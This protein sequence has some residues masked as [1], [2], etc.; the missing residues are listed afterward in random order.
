M[1]RK[2][3]VK[4][5]ANFKRNL[6]D[7]EHFLAEAEAPRACDSL[8]D[9]LLGTAIRNLERFPSMGRPFLA[10]AARS[11]ETANGLEALRA[12]LSALTP[13]PAT[14]RGY[15]MDDYLVLYAQ[16]GEDIHLLAIGHHRQLSF[17]FESHWGARS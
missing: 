14:L 12:E 2:L 1:T 6:E 8:L 7:I 5:T 9:E 13:D 4:L 16:I 11:V 3:V 10:R 17:D 15:I